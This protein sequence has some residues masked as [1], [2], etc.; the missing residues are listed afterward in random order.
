MNRVTV[1]FTLLFFISCSKSKDNRDTRPPVVTIQSPQNGQVFGPDTLFEIKG[2]AEDNESLGIIHIHV[3][4]KN[5]G[6]LLLDV[7]IYPS[8]KNAAFSQKL[9]SQSGINY[10]IQVL[11]RDREANEGSASAEVSCN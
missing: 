10:K 7:H 6:A 2:L 3:I 4:N 11:A 5:T 8:S 1:L 9:I